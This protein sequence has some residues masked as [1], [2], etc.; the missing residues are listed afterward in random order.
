MTAT[1]IPAND[2]ELR[3]L[4]LNGMSNAACTVSVV[5]TDGP[6]GRFGVTVSAM[7]SVSADTEKPTL[8][9]CIHTLSPAAKA[10]MA[11]GVFCV[12]VLR[13]DQS[14]ISDCFAGKLKTE[15]GDKFACTQW[16]QDAVGAPRVADALVAFSCKLLSN[17]QIGTH[18]VLFGAVEE[19]FSAGP[20]SPLIYANRAYGA[21][22]RFGLI[23]GTD[24]PSSSAGRLNLGV[25]HTFA[26]YVVPEILER[27]A[28]AGHKIELKLL[29]GD[30]RTIAEGLQVGDVDLALLYDLGLHDGVQIERLAALDPY[31]LLA[32][33]DP[34]AQHASLSLAE[35]S[36]HPLILLDAP[37]SGDYFLSLFREQSLTPEIRL[38]STSFEMV[39]GIVGRGIGYSLLATKPASNMSYD[40]RAL[41]TRP[42]RDKTRPSHIALARRLNGKSNPTADL[43]AAECRV[44]FRTFRG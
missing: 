37:P 6:A 18:H 38:R 14:Y 19:I 25:F 35:L 4:F 29:E 40:G 17:Q 20:G 11:N 33:G 12:N 36:K 44:F 7:A 31:V 16:A 39:R 23:S 3:Q 10:I 5:T 34:L 43:F 32:E 9:V 41:T 21:P 13:D 27:L 15:N 42:L 8:L 26:P 30:Q 24:A 22:A 2:P 28:I 1:P